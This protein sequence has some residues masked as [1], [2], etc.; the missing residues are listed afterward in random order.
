[1]QIR[2]SL[3]LADLTDLINIELHPRLMKSPTSSQAHDLHQ[4]KSPPMPH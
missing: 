3:T 4:K 1:M 2:P